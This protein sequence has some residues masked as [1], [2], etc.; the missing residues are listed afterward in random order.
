MSYF[1]AIPSRLSLADTPIDPPAWR[2][3]RWW[4]RDLGEGLLAQQA[5]RQPAALLGGPL[6]VLDIPDEQGERKERRTNAS[7]DDD[8]PDDSVQGYVLLKFTERCSFSSYKVLTSSPEAKR[9]TFADRPKRLI[10]LVPVKGIEPSTFALQ[11][12]KKID[13]SA[14]IAIHESEKYHLKT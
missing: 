11:V 9:P 5:R 8:E 3:F 2:V 10:S 12:R 1:A 7:A 6:A 4:R 14:L 13:L